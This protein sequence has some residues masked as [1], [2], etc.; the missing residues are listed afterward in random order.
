MNRNK[1]V[2]LLGGPLIA[3][4]KRALKKFLFFREVKWDRENLSSLIDKAKDF[5]IYN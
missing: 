4:N 1:R 3:N 5:F 2:N